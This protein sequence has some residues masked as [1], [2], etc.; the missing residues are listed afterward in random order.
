MN[1]FSAAVWVAIGGIGGW[2]LSKTADSIFESLVGSIGKLEF[3]PTW[4][5]FTCTSEVPERGTIRSQYDPRI[6]LVDARFHTVLIEGDFV[7]HRKATV[8]MSKPVLRFVHPRHDPFIFSTPTLTV[9]G[10]P[11]VVLT[12]PNESAVRIQLRIEVPANMV[13]Q[14]E[15][16]LP[17]LELS[18]ASGAQK[19]FRL[20]SSSFFGPTFSVWPR[21]GKRPVQVGDFPF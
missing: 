17:E 11:S 20:T 18:T 1:N 7:N 8:I 3:I 9:A 13:P 16:V 10:T 15:G 5:A 4:C 6:T 19:R 21:R 14:F 12:I 2:L